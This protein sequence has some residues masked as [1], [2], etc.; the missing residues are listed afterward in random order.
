MRNYKFKRRQ[1]GFWNF[2]IP[3][4]IG[5]L[6]SIGGGLLSSRGQRQ[7]NATN[8]RLN[9]ENNEFQERLSNSAVSRSVQDMKNAGINPMLAAINPSSTPSGSVARV[10]NEAEG[11]AGGVSSAAAAAQQGAL[12]NAQ[13]KAIQATTS[14]S[15]AQADK[16]QAETAEIRARLPFSGVTAEQN[17]ANLQTQGVKLGKE[18]QE[19]M[20][21]TQKGQVDLEQLQP[22]LIQYQRILN[23]AEAAGI[24]AKEAEAAIY[25]ALPESK[26]VEL[27][28][29]LIRGK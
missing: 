8:V 11:V 16:T 28:L 12:A 17:Y 29:K 24:P 13:L 9:R 18:I 23:Q 10:D 20:N 5:A 21:R 14:A 7:A 15:Q 25:K 19:I 3:A 6:G 27:F 2:V 1:A 4:A 26:A 22:L